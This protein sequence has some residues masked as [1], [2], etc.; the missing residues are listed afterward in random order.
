MV[1]R[2]DSV[3]T[4]P[5][6]DL[7]WHRTIRP[8][9][10]AFTEIITFTFLSRPPLEDAGL[11]VS[12]L[13]SSTVQAY[14]AHP[15]T[16]M[17]SRIR[18]RPFPP[19]L[20]SL[21]NIARILLIDC[22]SGGDTISRTLKMSCSSLTGN[23]RL[24]TRPTFLHPPTLRCKMNGTIALDLSSVRASRSDSF[25]ATMLQD[26]GRF[27]FLLKNATSRTALQSGCPCTFHRVAIS[28]PLSRAIRLLY[29]GRNTRCG[30]L[31][32]IPL[33]SHLC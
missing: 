19:S 30:V 18:I 20:N 16:T 28:L 8:F 10:Y 9:V 23:R 2:H 29:T 3:A 31:Y 33:H 17:V 15:G 26:D 12:E 5:P 21:C 24:I 13:W 4:S 11:A 7:Q 6:S 32:G 14:H 27:W 22:R 25:L 1:D